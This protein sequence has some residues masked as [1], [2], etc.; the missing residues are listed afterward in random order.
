[1]S[2]DNRKDS[3]VGQAGARLLYSLKRSQWLPHYDRATLRDVVAEMGE[4]FKHLHHNLDMNRSEA[5]VGQPSQAR[6]AT[7]TFLDTAL[8]RNRQCVLSYLMYRQERL[9]E[10]SW[11]HL[12]R[13]G[14]LPE[15]VKERLEQDEIMFA[16]QYNAVLDQYMVDLEETIGEHEFRL[17]ITTDAIP[18]KGDKIEIQLLENVQ[19]RSAGARFLARRQIVEPLVVSG[20]AKHMNEQ[21]RM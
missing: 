20:K 8:R 21:V 5:S 14:E 9:R 1:M 6:T 13:A 10:L 15:P 2:S 4:L 17:D 3:K 16:R 7:I 11:Q 19:E 18:A 12:G